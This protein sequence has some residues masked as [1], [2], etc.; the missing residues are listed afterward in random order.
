MRCSDPHT[1]VKL[2]SRAATRP[3]EC[4]TA[5]WRCRKGGVEG[6][7]SSRDRDSVR[8]LGL[9]IPSVTALAQAANEACSC[10]SLSIPTRDLRN[11]QIGDVRPTID[12]GQARLPGT[13]GLD[14][15]SLP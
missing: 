4:D 7:Q 13:V 9:A 8:N 2:Q 1:A 11:W 12:F 6:D 14:L 3:T 10:R 15:R 5:A